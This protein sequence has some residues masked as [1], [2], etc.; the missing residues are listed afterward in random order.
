MQHIRFRLRVF[1]IT[2]LA[3]IF[4]GSVG[5]MLIE[6]LSCMDALYFSVVTV[7]T[8]GYGDV[9]PQTDEGKAFAL[10]LIVMGVGTFLGVV[11]NATELM[12]NR[13]EQRARLEKLY[14]V[15]G[16][17]FSRVGTDLLALFV[18]A[19]G[20][21]ET[22]R[23]TYALRTDWSAPDF[24]RARQA[25]LRY[26][27]KIDTGRVDLDRLC[28]FLA[29]R[30][31][32]LLRLLENPTLLEHESFTDLLWAV[33]HLAEELAHRDDKSSLPDSDLAHLRGDITRAYRGLLHEWLAY[34]EHLKKRYPYLF[35]LACR[36]NPFNKAASVI[37][38][39][40]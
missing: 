3:V 4:C 23:D 30:E 31:E 37:I 33:F 40:S 11:A 39:E 21:L 35:S 20:A 25:L 14:M 24:Q 26:N 17:F 27:P 28:E 12:L 1:L 36:T 2:F 7:A 9:S 22:I 34:M 8:V 32:F 29:E 6:D 38:T 13:R 18:E 10:V 5:F 15:I 16:A 19:D